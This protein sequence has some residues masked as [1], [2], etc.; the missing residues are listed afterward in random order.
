MLG[1]PYTSSGMRLR[2][3]AQIRPHMTARR[4][5][6]LCYNGITSDQNCHKLLFFQLLRVEKNTSVGIYD[7]NSLGLNSA[8]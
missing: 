5:L 1:P 2:F 7:E 3:Q 8:S 4:A 6:N